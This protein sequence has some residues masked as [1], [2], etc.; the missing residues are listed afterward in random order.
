MARHVA[1][2]IVANGYAKECEIQIAYAIGVKEPVSINVNTFGSNAISEKEIENKVKETF[3]F[4]V[5]GMTKYLNL[6]KPIYT[7][8]SNYGHFG[9]EKMEWEKVIKF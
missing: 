9:K 6:K 2:N 7:K 8:T 5:E 4:S 3:D 1:K